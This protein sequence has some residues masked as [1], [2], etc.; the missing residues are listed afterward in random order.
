MTQDEA[1]AEAKRRWGARAHAK[2][3]LDKYV[4]L[5]LDITP[6]GWDIKKHGRVDQVI[7]WAETWE[8]AFALAGQ[9]YKIPEDTAADGDTADRDGAAVNQ[10]GDNS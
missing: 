3:Y 9:Q 8:E 6:P 1:D 5:L 7:A 10:K 4:E 2:P